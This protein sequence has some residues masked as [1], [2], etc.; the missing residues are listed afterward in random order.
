MRSVK[1]FTV[2]SWEKTHHA[3]RQR[4]VRA[5]EISIDGFSKITI[6]SLPQIQPYFDRRETRIY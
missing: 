2:S 6:L 1:E 5:G 3:L 4:A